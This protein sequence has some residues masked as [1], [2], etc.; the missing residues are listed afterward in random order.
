ML[1]ARFNVCL[2]SVLF[3]WILSSARA[4]LET[5]VQP[6]SY[7]IVRLVQFWEASRIEILDGYGRHIVESF[8]ILKRNTR[9]MSRYQYVDLERASGAAKL[10]GLIMNETDPF[11]SLISK[12]FG[13]RASSVTTDLLIKKS[14]TGKQV[15]EDI[16]TAW[17]RRK[18]NDIK[19]VNQERGYNNK[20]A[21]E[22]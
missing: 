2:K 9:N 8:P 21:E 4:I 15:E 13:H 11:Y 3:T 19:S 10:G 14:T 6:V 16:D 7:Y 1:Y 18:L 22:A 20:D 17:M 12:V 5:T